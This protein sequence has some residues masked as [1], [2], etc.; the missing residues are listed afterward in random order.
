MG[1]TNITIGSSGIHRERP[2]IVGELS[3]GAWVSSAV[4]VGLS[5][6]Q[7]TVSGRFWPVTSASK[8][9]LAENQNESLDSYARDHWTESRL[10]ATYRQAGEASLTRRAQVEYSCRGRPP[11]LTVGCL[12]G[13]FVT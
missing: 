5:R 6:S 10:P 3:A 4:D 7:R 9:C 1:V 8:Q 13:Y 2:E 11:A 12:R